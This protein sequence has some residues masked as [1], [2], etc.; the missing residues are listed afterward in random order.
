MVDENPLNPP[1]PTGE[2]VIPANSANAQAQPATPSA[3]QPAAT[4][5]AG[6]AT[7]KKKW[8]WILALCIVAA[9]IVLGGFAACMS[10]VFSV[11]IDSM[12][13]STPEYDRSDLYNYDKQDGLWNYYYGG[14][15]ATFEDIMEDFNVEAGDA[16]SAP[17]GR[18][19]YRIGSEFGIDPGLYLLEGSQAGVSNFYIFEAEESSDG[20]ET[21]YDLEVSVEYF[22]SYFA[23]LNE[24]DLIVY[25]P[26]DAGDTFTLA[27]NGSIGASAP[28]QSGCYRVGIDIPA[29]TYII[30]ANADEARTTDSESGAFVMRDLE[31]DD[32]SITEEAYVIKGGRQTITVSNGQFLELFAAIATPADQASQP[33]AQQPQ[34]QQQPKSSSPQ[35]VGHSEGA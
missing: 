28:Y 19:A 15:G 3:A 17:Y 27:P 12:Q 20:G 10:S 4:P 1:A 34:N 11:A 16:Q 6:A 7:Q 23:P 32:D 31:F 2:P 21:L 18:G 9:L 33:S 25:V 13:R 26:Q 8:P 35:Q 24:G 14:S 22:G 5:G 30:T 29:G